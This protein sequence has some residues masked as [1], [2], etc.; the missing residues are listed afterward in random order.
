M[1]YNTDHDTWQRAMD[2]WEAGDHQTSFAL[3]Q[4]LSA[5]D[6][7]NNYD[8]QGYLAFHYL[9]GLGVAQSYSKGLYWLERAV[10]QGDDVVLDWFRRLQDSIKRIEKN[11]RQLSPQALAL[12]TANNIRRSL[13]GYKNRHCR[14]MPTANISWA[15]FVNTAITSRMCRTAGFTG[16]NRPP[17]NIRQMLNMHWANATKMVC[18]K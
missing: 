11:L 5:T 8:S 16:I 18:G 6:S 2:A 15:D 17:H 10:L 14:T 9:N 12:F 13:R 4:K 7:G 1:T 3:L